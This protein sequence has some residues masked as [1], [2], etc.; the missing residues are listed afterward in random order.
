MSTPFE[1]YQRTGLDY[2]P[3]KVA[4]ITVD[5]PSDEVDL[6]FHQ[7]LTILL[8]KHSMENLSN[9]PDWILSE[10]LMGCLRTFDLAVGLRTRWYSPSKDSEP[11]VGL[12]GLEHEQMSVEDEASADG[13]EVDD[14]RSESGS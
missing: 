2:H 10:Y 11:L 9:T 3:P 5:M 6:T 4:E 12:V 14:A 7:E 13:V 1:R 8:N